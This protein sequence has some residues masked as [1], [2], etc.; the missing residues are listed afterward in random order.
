MHFV[1][2]S[3]TLL[4]CRRRGAIGFTL[5]LADA[6][7]CRCAAGADGIWMHQS[8]DKRAFLPMP[9]HRPSHRR[10]A[11]CRQVCLTTGLGLRFQPNAHP[12]HVDCP[13]CARGGCQRRGGPGSRAR[14]AAPPSRVHRA[15][16]AVRA[17]RARAADRWVVDDCRFPRGSPFWAP[18]PGYAQILSLSRNCSAQLPVCFPLALRVARQLAFVCAAGR[19]TFWRRAPVFAPANKHPSLP[20]GGIPASVSSSRRR[21]FLP[22]LPI[23]VRPFFSRSDCPQSTSRPS[24][25]SCGRW[26]KPPWAPRRRIPRRAPCC[27]SCALARR[28]PD[29]GSATLWSRWVL[30][31]QVRTVVRCASLGGCAYGAESCLNTSPS[32]QYE[33]G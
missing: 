19:D 5:G 12:T 32:C 15:G 18:R 8:G 29:C 30:P 1:R 2:H 9:V 28:W 21:S 26:R 7:Q 14:P 31:L 27:P 33:I 3:G 24:T 10:H 4:R 23:P 22:S 11:T 20:A 16:A 17:R 25:P 6:W 13:Q